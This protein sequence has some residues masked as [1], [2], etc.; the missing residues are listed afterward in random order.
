MRY[1]NGQSGHLVIEVVVKVFNPGRDLL[2]STRHLV[3]SDVLLCPKTELAS[4]IGAQQLTRNI[5]ILSLVR[6]HDNI[7]SFCW[8]L[9]L[10]SQLIAELESFHFLPTFKIYF[11]YV[12]SFIVVKKMKIRVSI[13]EFANLNSNLKFKRK[14]KVMSCNSISPHYLITCELF[15]F[16]DAQ[17]ILNKMKSVFPSISS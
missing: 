5:K 10:L 9:K 2:S 15:L 8:T 4:E 13:T 12:H 7:Y 3:E 14:S 6:K 1:P 11:V 17:I 16:A